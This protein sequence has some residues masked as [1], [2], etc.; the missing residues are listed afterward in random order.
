MIKTV[1]ISSKRQITIP[2]KLFEALNLREGDRLSVQVVNNKLIMQK[3]QALLDDLAGS[4]ELPE[5]Y[6][7][8]SLDFIIRDAKKEYFKRKK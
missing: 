1:R 8:R 2:A 7:N 4:L 3:S 6:K 5:E